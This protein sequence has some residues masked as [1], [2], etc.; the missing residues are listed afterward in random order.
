MLRWGEDGVVKPREIRELKLAETSKPAE[1]AEEGLGFDVEAVD[2]KHLESGPVSAAD[3]FTAHTE[4]SQES[5][6][7]LAARTVLHPSD[8]AA[9]GAQLLSQRQAAGIVAVEAFREIYVT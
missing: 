1:D 9:S 7:S 8:F 5:E 2:L 3:I 6:A 4:A